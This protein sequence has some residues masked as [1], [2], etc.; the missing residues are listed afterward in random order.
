MEGLI[1]M[2]IPLVRNITT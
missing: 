2:L 1:I